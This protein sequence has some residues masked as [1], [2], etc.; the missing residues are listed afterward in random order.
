MKGKAQK[1][2]KRTRNPKRF[3]NNQGEGFGGG[4]GADDFN[5]G[6]PGAVLVEVVEAIA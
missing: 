3:S 6:L 1:S 5:N 4:G 2:P